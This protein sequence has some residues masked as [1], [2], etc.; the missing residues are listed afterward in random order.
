MANIG[1]PEAIAGAALDG[2]RD[3]CLTHLDRIV[4]D[5]RKAFD[6]AAA[7]LTAAHERIGDLPL[8]DT[9]SI[10]AK[11]GDVAE[12][13]GTAKRADHTVD[14]LLNGCVSLMTLVRVTLDPRHRALKLAPLTHAA[15]TALVAVEAD[16]KVSAQLAQICASRL[17]MRMRRNGEEIAAAIGA[18]L[19][20][21]LATLQTDAPLLPAFFRGEH[22]DTLTPQTFAARTRVRDAYAR[23]CST[24]TGL[25]VLYAGAVTDTANFTLVAA[26]SLRFAAPPTFGTTLA[27]Y[28]FR[29]ALAGRAVKGQGMA[30]RVGPSRGGCSSPP[31]LAHAGAT[32]EWATPTQVTER[33]DRIVAG[34]VEA[35]RVS[36]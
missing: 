24:Q 29:D 19:A 9:T 6:A 31:P 11:G 25:S 7:T 3:A 30:A 8:A 5:W 16:A 26:A 34:M 21:D 32:F 10:L 33:A 28:T 27:A 36:A 18:A 35:E 20:D 2:I 13:W 15:A 17:R 14:Q 22:A 4:T 23:I 1:L 12:V